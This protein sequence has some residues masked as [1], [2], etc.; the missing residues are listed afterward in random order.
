MEIETTCQICGRQIKSKN[1]VIA[2]H[3]YTRPGD[4]YQTRSCMGARYLPYEESRDR[5]AQAINILSEEIVR[6]TSQLVGLRANPPATLNVEKLSFGRV[7]GV[8]EMSRPDGFDPFNPITAPVSKMSYEYAFKVII[9]KHN[10]NLKSIA[11][12]IEYLKERY[13]KWTPK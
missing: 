2:H 9:E 3:G 12:Q 7:F 13:E 8:V 11:G 1:G 6:I 10:R 5:I 4:G